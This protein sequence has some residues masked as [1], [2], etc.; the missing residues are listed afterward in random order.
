MIVILL[1]INFLV[2]TFIVTILVIIILVIMIM[3]VIFISIVIIIV[4]III[5]SIINIIIGVMKSNPTCACYFTSVLL[6]PPTI[7][8]LNLRDCSHHLSL[9]FINL[10]SSHSAAHCSPTSKNAATHT[11]K[12][13]F[14]SPLTETVFLL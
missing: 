5:I 9:F 2:I 10:S 7:S 8:S 11:F 1:I 13:S 4:V 14:M 12:F 6:L 3:I